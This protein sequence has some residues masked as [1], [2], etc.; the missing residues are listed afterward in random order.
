M[1]GHHKMCRINMF[2]TMNKIDV[3]HITDADH[4]IDDPHPFLLNHQQ[5]YQA[6]GGARTSV[7]QLSAFICGGYLVTRM[8]KF[9]SYRFYLHTYPGKLTL[10]FGGVACAYL[11]GVIGKRVFGKN[12][13]LRNHRIAYHYVK[14]INRSD[15]HNLLMKKPPTY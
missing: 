6:K 14:E 9:R 4:I 13:A 3:S 11:A 7:L 5:L 1:S 2:Q 8:N 15:C 12:E 10:F